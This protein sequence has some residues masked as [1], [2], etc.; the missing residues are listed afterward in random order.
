MIKTITP[1]DVADMVKPLEP[2]VREV[3]PSALTTVRADADA[4]AYPTEKELYWAHRR[5]REAMWW[6]DGASFVFDNLIAPIW[7]KMHKNYWDFIVAE[8]NRNNG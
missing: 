7:R 4:D 6:S 5:K 8:R 1:L 3:E 2:V